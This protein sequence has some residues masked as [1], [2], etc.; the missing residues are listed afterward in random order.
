M[1]SGNAPW[2]LERFL[3][4]VNEVHGNKFDYSQVKREH[5]KN[6]ESH[7]P[8]ICRK[9]LHRCV[10]ARRASTWDEQSSS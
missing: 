1:C 3:I 8:V 2:T 6:S 9:C 10:K 4:K 7:I 5:I